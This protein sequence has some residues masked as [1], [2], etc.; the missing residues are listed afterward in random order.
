MMQPG[1][2]PPGVQEVAFGSTIP[3]RPRLPLTR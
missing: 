2:P 1:S 3:L